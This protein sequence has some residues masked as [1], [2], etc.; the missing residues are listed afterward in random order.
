MDKNERERQR[1]K[2]KKR[3]LDELKDMLTSKGRRPTCNRWTEEEILKNT[4]LYIKELEKTAKTI[5]ICIP[6]PLNEL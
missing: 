4:F 3:S 6:T 1:V 5:G 2:L